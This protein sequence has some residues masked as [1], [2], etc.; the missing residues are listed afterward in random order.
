MIINGKKNL[1]KG[2]KD[3]NNDILDWNILFANF[4]NSV[5]QVCCVCRPAMKVMLVCR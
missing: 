3:E 1:H 2:A 5:G 4:Y